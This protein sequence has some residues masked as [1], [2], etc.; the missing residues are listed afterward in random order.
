LYAA[1]RLNLPHVLHIREY[2]GAGQNACF[3]IPDVHVR[4]LLRK[5]NTKVICNSSSIA[6]YYKQTL[7]ISDTRV[8]YNGIEIPPV[9]NNVVRDQSTILMVGY[10]DERKN[11]EEALYAIQ[12]LVRQEIKVKLVM[13]GSGDPVYI[14]KLKRIV[15]NASLESCVEFAGKIEDV[16]TLYA[17]CSCLVHCAKMEPWGRVIVEAMLNRCPVI[18]ADS[19]GVCEIV[20]DKHN[21]LLY[22]RGDIDHLT[23][24]ITDVLS[25]KV[26]TGILIANAYENALKKYSIETY[27]SS[28]SY[29]VND[30]LEKQ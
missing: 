24:L 22:K 25:G 23:Q 28:I 20:T 29:I 30:S 9:N 17:Q 21:G 19:E 18:A 2:V 13:A 1:K 16:N 26:S 7:A 3:I 6:S 5:T 15:Q 27:V 12:K 4:D 10:L 8:V 14:E 11:Q